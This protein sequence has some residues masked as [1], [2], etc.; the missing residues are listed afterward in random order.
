MTQKAPKWI[1][2]GAI[3]GKKALQEPPKG[4]PE[5]EE[6]K[7]TQKSL[8]KNPPGFRS[9]AIFCPPLPGT[10]PFYRLLSEKQ[11]QHNVHSLKALPFGRPPPLWRQP[12]AASPYGW[13]SGGWEGIRR[14]KIMPNRAGIVAAK[15]YLAAG[16]EYLLAEYHVA[17]LDLP[18]A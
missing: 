8:K 1:P 16:A 12:K 7:D 14:G 13:V 15:W 18:R 5:T 4:E 2:N 11:R 17:Y 6:E 3:G 10:L 9:G